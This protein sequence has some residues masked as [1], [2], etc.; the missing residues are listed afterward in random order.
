MLEQSKPPEFAEKTMVE[1]KGIF[2]ETVASEHVLPIPENK[3][4]SKTL[5]KLGVRISNNTQKS[6]R[7]CSYDTIFPNLIEQNGKHLQLEGGRNVSRLI[8][9]SDCPFVHPGESV[10]FFLDG[11]LAWKNNKLQLEGP[12]R[13]GGLWRFEDLKPGIYG[14]RFTYHSSQETVQISYPEQ[15][16][17]TDI[18]TGQVETPIT[19]ISLVLPHN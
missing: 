1:Q 13:F 4:S 18:W 17:L 11:T 15:K 3:P 6:M 12:D 5:V 8:R 7:F 2:F 10:T 9:E 14:F 16:I 19:E